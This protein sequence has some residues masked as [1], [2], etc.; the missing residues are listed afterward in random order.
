M[1][2]LANL[3]KNIKRYAKHKNAAQL[4]KI[5]QTAAEVLEKHKSLD[6]EIIDK[7]HPE[8]I[9]Y[10]PLH[11]AINIGS[12]EVFELLIEMGASPFFKPN[13]SQS[14]SVILDLANSDSEDKKRLFNWLIQDEHS[15]IFTW[16][17]LEKNNNELFLEFQK[18]GLVP[19]EQ[20]D[21]LPLH[22]AI[23]AGRLDLVKAIIS[24]SDSIEKAGNIVNKSILKP[25]IINFLEEKENAKEIL[26]YLLKQANLEKEELIKLP[27]LIASCI[28]KVKDNLV[29]EVVKLLVKHGANPNVFTSSNGM[30]LVMYA[31]AHG[32][33]KLFN[34]LLKKVDAKI[35]NHEA[36]SSPY[37]LAFQLFNISSN[38]L[39][40]DIPKLI[41]KLKERGVEF[42]RIISKPVLIEHF[43]MHAKGEG[44]V[45][46][47]PILHFYLSSLEAETFFSSIDKHIEVIQTLIANGADPLAKA[48]FTLTKESFE[49]NQKEVKQMELTAS[50][51]FKNII[52]K[53]H[54]KGSLLK[55]YQDEQAFLAEISSKDKEEQKDLRK[56]FCQFRNLLLVLSGQE[57]NYS[58]LPKSKKSDKS[59]VAV[60]VALKPVIEPNLAALEPLSIFDKLILARTDEKQDSWKVLKKELVDFVKEAQTKEDFLERIEK[61]KKPLQLHYDISTSSKGEIVYGSRAYRFFHYFDTY[62][63]P[64]SWEQLR[65]WGQD[66]YEVDINIQ[67]ERNNSVALAHG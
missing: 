67:N 50:E 29:Y 28:P 63:C 2:S 9:H 10:T 30:T 16:K 39:T 66:K 26:I 25:A 18:S 57:P 5:K 42:D 58:K 56:L 38:G 23:E 11:A 35:L 59:E 17:K 41:V 46:N 44:L 49:P 19:E 14:M 20:S 31:M 60:T 62:K 32:Y 45:E 37:Y 43:P 61:C 3:L 40:S 22:K 64:N 36:F 13:N 4:E 6:L 47:M 54:D 24:L 53:I 55:N 34:F 21:I 7:K 27:A 52:E 8:S 1:S 33:K 48:K 12:L 51:Y 15:P 65:K